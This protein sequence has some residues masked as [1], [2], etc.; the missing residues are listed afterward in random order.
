MARF[1]SDENFPFP[2]VSELGRPGYDVLTAFEA[3]QANAGVPDDKVLAFVTAA[4]RAVFT[5]NRDDFIRLH[6]A[7]AVH[8]GIVVCT[9]D[10]DYAGQAGRIVAGVAGPPS[11]T[12]LLIRVNRPAADVQASSPHR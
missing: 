2:V 11:L 3:G 1:Y 10:P 4:G 6:R 5:L 7:S 12:G 9:F 8:A